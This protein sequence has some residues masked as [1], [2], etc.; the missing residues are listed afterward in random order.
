MRGISDRE[1]QEQQWKIW[2][3]AMVER[4]LLQDGLLL[5]QLYHL[6]QHPLRDFPLRRL[7]YFDDVI[8][9]DNRDRVAVRVE[10][11]AFLRD[12][13]HDDRIERFRGEFFT[14]VFQCILRFCGKSYDDL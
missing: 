3:A 12:V 7:W 13:V 9:S 10:A 14:R 2:P 8:M 11:H 4:L 6:V 5:P 1:Y